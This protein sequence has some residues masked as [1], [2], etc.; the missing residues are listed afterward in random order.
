M[1]RLVLEM[2]QSLEAMPGVGEEPFIEYLQGGVRHDTA[3]ALMRVFDN[4]RW[5]Q[6]LELLLNFDSGY[7]LN[8]KICQRF[9]VKEGKLG[10]LWEVTIQ[11]AVLQEAIYSFRAI[12]MACVHELW[13]TA[14]PSTTL[15]IQDRVRIVAAQLKATGQPPLEAAAI[16]AAPELD[17]LPIDE[18]EA[19]IEENSTADAPAQPV[20]TRRPARSRKALGV[21]NL[22]RSGEDKLG[23]IP[24]GATTADG[25]GYSIK[26]PQPQPEK[27]NEHVGP[28]GGS[29]RGTRR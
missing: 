14:Q 5:E 25:K 9:M 22:P 28:V 29:R 10:F 6:M 23:V 17:H 15:P 7:G 16:A 26:L 2:R 4:G 3:F 11:G 12:L 20:K 21:P 27:W 24:D 1:E 19:I 18:V 8:F 13:L